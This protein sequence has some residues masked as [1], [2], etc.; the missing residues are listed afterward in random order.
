MLEAMSPRV[1]IVVRTKDRPD[2]LAR[3]LADVA[4]QAFPDWEAV[5]VNDGGD[6]ERVDRVVAGSGIG[7]RVAVVHIAP[8]EGGRCVAANTGV[9]AVRADLVVLHDDD[10]R[11]DPRFLR[12][13]VAWLDARPE[14]AAV[15]TAT[16][17]VY[18]ELRGGRWT[19]TSRV[20]FWAGMTGVSL[21]EMLSI[22]RMVPIGVLY[23]RSLHDEVGWY[24]ET[25]DAVEDWDLY[26]R[27]LRR[28]PVGFIGGEPLAYWSQRPSVRGA[29][30]NSMF[31]IADR[32]ERDDARVRDRALR[33]W[34]E[35]N[36][37]GL[38]LYL[39]SAEKRILREVE[40][41]LD[42]QRARIVAEIYD[43]HPLWRRVRRLRP[44]RSGRTGTA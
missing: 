12:E 9:R 37:P 27:I 5:V 3:A 10:D 15:A 20:P 17:I 11:W 30:A 25:L 19:E 24:D 33:E 7:D 26:L 40:R 29:D 43:R 23:R 31:E 28:H 13:T 34:V 16:T 41:M 36:G 18:E 42:E 39:A 1:G 8:G 38:P 44:R 32:H 35:A 14:D 2:F 22:N 6:P 4:A 21:A